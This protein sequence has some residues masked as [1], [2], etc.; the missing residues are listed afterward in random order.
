[1]QNNTD[2]IDI[3]IRIKRLDKTQRYFATKFKRTPSQVSQAIRGR[4]PGLLKKI[5][6]HIESLEKQQREF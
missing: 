1:M 5:L 3:F 6:R 4:Q 2:I